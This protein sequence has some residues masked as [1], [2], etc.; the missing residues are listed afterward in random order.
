VK[1]VHAHNA[2][3][4]SLHASTK[5]A[6]RWGD[7]S[8]AVEDIKAMLAEGIEGHIKMRTAPLVFSEYVQEDEVSELESSYSKLV[9]YL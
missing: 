2:D 5:L 4:L 7:V 6:E 8:E 3:V 9:S 1:T